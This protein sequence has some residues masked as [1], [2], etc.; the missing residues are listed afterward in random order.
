MY[1]IRFIIITILIVIVN[2]HYLGASGQKFYA[3]DPL[4][5]DPDTAVDAPAPVAHALSDY[6]DFIL[7]S[8]GHPGDSNRGRAVNINT[9]GEVPDSSWFA[10]RHGR[11]RMGIEDLIRGPNSGDGPSPDGVWTITDAKTEGITPGFNIRDSRGDIYVIKFDPPEN[12]EMA[13]AAEVISTKFFHA[14]GYNVPENYLVA[15]DRER[16]RVDPGATLEVALGQ[17]RPMSE[18]DLDQIL[19]RTYQAPDGSY[20]VIASKFLP[21]RPLGPFSYS[22][23][24]SDDPN[25]IFPHENRRE[26]RGLRVLASWINH[27]DSRAINSQDILITETGLSYI[28]HHLID[29]GS[30]LGSGSVGMQKHRAG[31]EYIWEPGAAL[32]RIFTLGLWDRNWIRVNYPDISSIG[33]FESEAFRPEEWKSEYPNPAFQRSTP[34]DTY[35]GAKIA[36]KFT[37]EEIG[38]IVGTGQFG[39]SEAEAYL[40]QRL[41]ERR[42]K[43]GEYWFRQV[44]TADNFTLTDTTLSFER[45]ASEYGFDTLPTDNGLT[46]FRFENQT[47][48]SQALGAEVRYTS[49]AIELPDAVRM[50]DNGTYFQA[51]LREVDR[52]VR[53]YLR[54]RSGTLEVVGIERDQRSP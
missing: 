39:D 26:L 27:D 24:R 30:T 22:G 47:G 41:I 20:R 50:S 16:L 51:S 40:I 33:R 9:L 11:S 8:F 42:D 10:N 29:F 28:R 34:E 13:T 4:W 21:G 7:H 25:D 53:V 3:D 48:Q 43:I 14:M 31:W 49:T 2:T 38:A 45:L 46:W 18:E 35:W 15:V 32:G 6:Y 23:T 12:P 19:E 37:D 54:N 5:L 17:Q 36:M 44:N 1:K 52:E